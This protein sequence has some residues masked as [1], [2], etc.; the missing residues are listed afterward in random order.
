MAAEELWSNGEIAEALGVSRPD[1]HEGGAGFSQRRLEGLADEPRPGKPRKITDEQVQ[2]VPRPWR[3]RRRM[4]R[5][6]QG[7]GRDDPGR[8]DADLARAFGL[9]PHRQETWKLSKDYAAAH[10][11]P[12]TRSTAT[13]A[14]GSTPGTRNPRPYVWTKTADQILDSI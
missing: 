12:S 10:T 14:I 11:A 5:T 4:R 2:A 1:G 13:S 3:A 9:Q 7:K 8:G 6:G